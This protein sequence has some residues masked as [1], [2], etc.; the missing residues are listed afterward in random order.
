MNTIDPTRCMS[1]KS[2]GS[3]IQCTAAKKNGT[4]YCGTHLRAK[5]LVRIDS[6]VGISSIEV[7]V[8]QPKPKKIVIKTNTKTDKSVYGYYELQ[9]IKNVNSHKLRKTCIHFGINFDENEIEKSF[10]DLKKTVDAIISP[11]VS[12]T[13]QLIS[14]QKTFR[15]W[16][17]F[18]RNKSNNKEDCGT[19]ESIYDIPIEYYIDYQDSDGFIYAFDIRTI[20]IINKNEKSVNPYTQKQFTR[21]FLDKLKQKTE[22]IQ[23]TNGE[24]KYDSPKL[25]DEQ[26]YH[27]FLIR[28]FQKY[29][30]IGQYTDILWFEQLDLE[31]LKIFYKNA[32]D[33]FSYRAQLSDDIKKK[34]VKDGKFFHNFLN[35]MHS[36]RS[37]H[38][39]LLQFEI[40]REMERI[41]DE[42][43]DK[44]YKTLGVNL[45]L[46]VLVEL[47]QAA[48]VA[49]PHL[50]QST[51]G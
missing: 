2:K 27:Q 24:I 14:I 10:Y 19:L 18:R 49:L 39:R 29:D 44:E 36:F 35:N 43:E 17:I 31:Q 30:M 38:K 28:V 15:M 8:Q 37:K 22:K 25:T 21:N 48:A 50:V 26:R 33:M 1:I 7:P 51:F 42:G 13:D 9:K 32:N 12:F 11:Y 46:T 41:V 34:I 4:D 16:N 20:E 40:L 47:S 5:Y 3:N 6:I 23:K 45:I